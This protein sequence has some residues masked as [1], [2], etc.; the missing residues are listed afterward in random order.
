MTLFDLVQKS[1]YRYENKFVISELTPAEIELAVK[2][3]PALF[4]E[5]FYERTINNIYFDS[6]D[7][8]SY[9]DNLAGVSERY[10]FRIRWYGNTL[11]LVKNPILEIKIKQNA[12]GQKLSYPLVDF[13]IDNSFSLTDIEQVFEQSQLPELIRAELTA[14]RFV[15]LSSYRRK[16]FRSFDHKFRLTIDSRLKFSR[17]QDRP[18][19]GLATYTGPSATVVELKYHS[20]DSDQADLVAGAFPFRISKNSKYVIGVERLYG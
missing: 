11:G 15:F 6:I 7:F 4:S 12:L 3:H 20:A 17:L 16:Y 14:M 1:D 5:I 10:K 2:L 19:L 18:G 8:R 9:F 13:V